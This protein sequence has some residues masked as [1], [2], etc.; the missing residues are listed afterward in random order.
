MRR[1]MIRNPL[2]AIV[3]LALAAA[4]LADAAQAGGV[5]SFRLPWSAAATAAPAAHAAASRHSPSPV[6]ASRP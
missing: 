5:G 2:Q 3:G 1:S 6:G 4:L